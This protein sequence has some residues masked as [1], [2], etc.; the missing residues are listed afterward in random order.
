M[1]IHIPFSSTTYTNRRNTLIS[2]MPDGKILFL[3]NE[4]SSINFRDNWHPYRQDSTFL[5]YGALSMPSIALLID[6][7]NGSTKLFADDVSIDMVIW[8]GPQP[9]ISSLAD[10]IGITEVFTYNDL[11]NHLSGKIHYLPPYRASQ[12]QTLKQLLGIDTLTPSLELIN[13]IQKQRSIKTDEEVVL[14]EEACRLSKGMHAEVIQ[15]IKPGVYEYE[16]VAIASKFALENNVRWSFPPILTKNGQTLHNHYHGHK[17][18]EDDIVLMDSGVE[19]E[20]GYCGDITRT[21]PAN[22]KFSPERQEIYDLVHKMYKESIEKA[23][24]GTKYLDVHLHASKVLVEGLKE[25]GLMKGDTEEAV[26]EG[27]HAMFFQHGLGHLMGLD[28]HDMENFGEENIGY[29]DTVKKSTQFGL[30]SL[31]LGKELEVGNVITI[32]PGIYIIPE[33]IDKF[34][35]E[36][37]FSNFVNYEMLNKMRGLGGIRIE[38]DFLITDQ[39][40]KMLGGDNPLP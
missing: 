38:D 22:G 37:R 27:A 15:H 2:N 10:Q 36:G 11:Q 24:S 17:I 28:V 23:N 35:A 34:E 3:A 19:L 39:G 6:V 12:A 7:E 1:A 25:I 20:S 32:E 16:L 5:Y 31:R 18:G 13:A 26:T 8:T 29:T 14:I 21:T 9:K 40:A 33:L 4:E 30:K